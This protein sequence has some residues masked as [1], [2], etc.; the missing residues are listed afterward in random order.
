MNIMLPL[1]MNKFSDVILEQ[2]DED[3]KEKIVEVINSVFNLINDP[4][5]RTYILNK[6]YDV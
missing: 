1:K 3:N 2:D 6:I 4:M 5:Y